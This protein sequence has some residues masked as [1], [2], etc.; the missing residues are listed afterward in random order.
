MPSS[1]AGKSSLLRA[2]AGLWGRGGGDIA[3]PPGDETMFL[4]HRA[5]PL[6]AGVTAVCP[7]GRYGDAEVQYNWAMLLGIDREN[8]PQAKTVTDLAG[9]GTAFARAQ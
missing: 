7:R 1:G 6:A 2:V 4:P 5:D 9:A 8:V 3:R